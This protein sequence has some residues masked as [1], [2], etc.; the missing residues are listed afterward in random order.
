VI[1]DGHGRVIKTVGDGAAIA[2]ALQ[3]RVLVARYEL[4]P[5]R[6]VAVRGYRH[7]RPWLLTRPR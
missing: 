4:R 1:A 7:L 2:L 3:D 5:I 6:P